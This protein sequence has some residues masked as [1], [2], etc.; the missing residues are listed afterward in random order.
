VPSIFRA[1]SRRFARGLAALA[2]VPV[3][4]AAQGP[5]SGTAPPAVLEIRIE[6]VK[7]GSEARYDAIEREVAA[8]CRRFD[9]PQPYLVLESFASPQEIYRLT[10]YRS[11]SDVARVAA[12]YA[13]N[14]PLLAEFGRATERKADVIDDS[15]EIVARYRP[16]LSDTSPWLVG[17]LPFALIVEGSVE[18]GSGA[19]FDLANGRQLVVIPVANVEDAQAIAAALGPTAKRFALRPE[20]SKPH[21]AWIIG[22]PALWPPSLRED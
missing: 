12:A 22:N 17:T 4:L 14:A 9:C 19:V 20:W 18:P 8:V 1:R 16:D 5:L 15:I 11:D 21:S 10:G 2:L 6:R 7:P 3:G 13:S